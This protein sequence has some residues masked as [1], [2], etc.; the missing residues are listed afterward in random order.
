M[1]VPKQGFTKRYTYGGSGI[2]GSIAKL[3]TRMF[4]SG[5]AKQL[6]SSA[7]DVGK[8]VAKEG[9]KKALEAGTTAAV[10]AGK[11]LVQKA[12]KPKSKQILEKYTAQPQPQ[13]Q[14]INSL[15]AGSSIEIQN[16]VKKLNTG[17][18]IKKI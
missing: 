2:F 4:T 5:A 12:L 14:N 18:G 15:I 1:I 17:M 10:D 3:L 11:K 16:L 13:T 9:A 8:K 6:A 7:L